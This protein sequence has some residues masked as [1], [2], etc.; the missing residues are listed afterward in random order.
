MPNHSHHNYNK[1]KIAIGFTFFLTF[2]FFSAHTAFSEE[3]VSNYLPYDNLFKGSQQ[4]ETKSSSVPVS[5]AAG[6]VQGLGALREQAR[7]YRSQGIELQRVGNYDQALGLYKKAIELDPLYAVPY[8]DMAIIFEIQ[9][10]KDKAEEYYLKAIKADQYFLSAYSNLALFYEGKR[11]LNKA[12]YYWGKR[13]E[14][15]DVNDPWTQRAIQRRSDILALNSGVT[16]DP[17]Q[18]ER[19]AD[20]MNEIEARKDN[21]SLSKYYFEK[22]K[23]MHEGGDDV[24]ALK[25]GIDAMQLDESNAEIRDFVDNIRRTLLSE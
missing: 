3:A 4:I 14:L 5:Y 2:S 20:L 17:E 7:L 12:V 13:A 15:G 18:E 23:K 24:G 11:D 1:V 9:G 21:K 8:N 10:L 22:A 16:Y 19:I 6:E 25:K